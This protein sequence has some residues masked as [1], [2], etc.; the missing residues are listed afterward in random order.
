MRH[1]VLLFAC[2]SLVPVAIDATAQ[3]TGA[4]KRVTA[5]ERGSFLLSDVQP[6]VYDVKVSAEALK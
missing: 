3:G 5:D 1:F 6:G 2:V 4:V